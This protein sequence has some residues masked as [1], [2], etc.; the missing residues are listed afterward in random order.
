MQLQIN[1]GVKIASRRTHV[2]R[3][4]VL[5]NRTLTHASDFKSKT[6]IF[7][8]NVFC[9]PFLF[10]LPDGVHNPERERYAKNVE[11]QRS[12]TRTCDKNKNKD[13]KI[14]VQNKGNLGKPRKSRSNDK[15]NVTFSKKQTKNCI[16]AKKLMKRLLR[17]Y[18]MRRTLEPTGLF[19][20]YYLFC[21]CNDTE[22]V[23]TGA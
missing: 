12:R 21:F 18:E 2:S 16:K 8:R 5:Y 13:L 20:Y 10:F 6:N 7:E 15:M 1:T 4:I 22:N 19:F 14:R 11:A 3:P 23:E 9:L 17:G